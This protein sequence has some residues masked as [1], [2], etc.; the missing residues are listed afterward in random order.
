MLNKTYT[1]VQGDMWD[2][3]AHN[4]LGSASHTETLMNANLQHINIHIFPAGIVLTLPAVT[5][6]ETP[7]TLPPWKQVTS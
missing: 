3:I 5:D 2:L 6:N 7:S 1:T 4:Q